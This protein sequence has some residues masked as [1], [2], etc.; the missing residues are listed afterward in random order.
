MAA[1]AEVDARKQLILE[2]IRG[3]PD[4]PKKV[5]SVA[6]KLTISRM[7]DCLVEQLANLDSGIIFC[8]SL[9]ERLVRDRA[10]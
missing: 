7:H 8:K 5:G 2:S 10:M 6:T 1:P 4:F 9:R 3:I